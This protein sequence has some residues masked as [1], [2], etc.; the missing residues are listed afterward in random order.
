MESNSDHSFI[1][2]HCFG[3][4]RGR[5]MEIMLAQMLIPATVQ[6]ELAQLNGSNYKIRSSETPIISKCFKSKK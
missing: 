6:L 2:S 3:S 5:E 4:I 1:Q